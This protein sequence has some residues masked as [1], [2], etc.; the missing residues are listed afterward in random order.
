MAID[1]DPAWAVRIPKSPEFEL[2]CPP[3]FIYAIHHA[4]NAQAAI[5]GVLGRVLYDKHTLNSAYH[6][7]VGSPGREVHFTHR[8]WDNY[9]DPETGDPL[10]PHSDL[11]LLTEE[12]MLAEFIRQAN[13]CMDESSSVSR[14][15]KGLLLYREINIDEF[16]LLESLDGT[17]KFKYVRRGIERAKFHKQKE[18][19][20][21]FFAHLNGGSW[22]GA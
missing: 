13:C 18:E 10:P 11:N 6:D 19:E 21:K 22:N 3:N 14:A 1:A 20:A 17:A 8:L 2:I 16:H 7:L 15:R 9:C 4:P 5:R 12:E